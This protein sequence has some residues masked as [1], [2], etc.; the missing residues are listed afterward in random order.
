MGVPQISLITVC[1]NSAATIEATLES[2]ASQACKN[3]EHIVVDGGS[4]D[5]TLAIIE[6][7]RDKL[8]IIV[9]KPDQGIYDAM[10]KGIALSSGDIIGILNAD[11]FYESNDVINL[12]MDIFL[13]Y[14]N[15][16]IV[17]GDVV[18]VKPENLTK[19]IRYYGAKSFKPWKLRFGW[20]P[21]HPATFVRRRVYEESGLYQL[22]YKIA[23]DYEIFIR[24]LLIKKYRFTWIDKVMVRMRTG[25]IST[26]GFKSSL[27]LNQEIVRACR[28]NGIYT[29]L[30]F[31][32]SKIPFKLLEAIRY[33]PFGRS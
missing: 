13:R 23:S 22:S 1:Y 29:N 27:L 4:T 17:F 12:V 3:F 21:P 15:I 8:A 24:W 2:V 9:S 32:L 11:D 10:N 14:P 18:F 25:G 31:I 19:V 33:L 28:A 20:M 16:D 7:H 6:K 30:F 26:S 5:G